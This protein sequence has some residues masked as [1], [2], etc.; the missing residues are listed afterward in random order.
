MLGGGKLDISIDGGAALQLEGEVDTHE[1]IVSVRCN[2]GGVISSAS[3]LLDEN[4]IYLFSQVKTAL[5]F[6][7]IVK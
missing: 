6:S 5:Y 3:V 4:R 2:V 1:D 7:F